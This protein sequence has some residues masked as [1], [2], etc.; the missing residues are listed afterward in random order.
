MDALYRTRQLPL[1][2]PT[3]PD[4]IP[5]EGEYVMGRYA[6]G[7]T[8]LV[9][10]VGL[11]RFLESPVY[12]EQMHELRQS[13]VGAKLAWSLLERRHDRLHFTV[14]P[15]LHERVGGEPVGRLVEPA[16]SLAPFRVRIT[17][18]WLSQSFNVGRLYLTVYPELDRGVDR[19]RQAQRSLGERETV[20]YVIGFHNVYEPPGRARDRRAGRDHPDLSGDRAGGVPDLRATR[21]RHPRRPPARQLARRRRPVCNPPEITG[22]LD[23]PR[24]DP[25]APLETSATD[26]VFGVLDHVVSRGRACQHQLL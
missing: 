3:H 9:G 22:V 19:L 21:D 1:V 5:R 6:G 26:A 14:Q 4:V 16:R 2:N 15:S 25:A 8:S 17:G 20:F 13:R 23:V 12:R 7:R 10:F 11:D 24:L 18:P